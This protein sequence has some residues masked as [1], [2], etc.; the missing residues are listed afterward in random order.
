MYAIVMTVVSFSKLLSLDFT[1]RVERL[2]LR[3]RMKKRNN[4]NAETKMGEKET[5]KI[6]IPSKE[7]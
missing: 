3:D 4:E 2:E 7:G 6:K 1:T 5:K